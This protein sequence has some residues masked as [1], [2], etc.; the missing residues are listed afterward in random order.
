MATSLLELKYKH[1]GRTFVLGKSTPEE[2]QPIADHYLGQGATMLRE[3][4]WLTR[5]I[6]MSSKGSPI[7][8]AID[9]LRFGP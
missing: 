9:P 3:G 7:R 6:A 1:N 8:K 4:R 2:I 5:I